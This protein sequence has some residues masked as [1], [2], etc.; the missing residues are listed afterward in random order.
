[1]TTPSLT[2]F[3]SIIGVY[4]WRRLKVSLLKNFSERLPSSKLSFGEFF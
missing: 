4:G 2:T 1:M 3:H